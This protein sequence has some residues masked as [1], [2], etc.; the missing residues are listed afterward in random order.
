MERRVLNLTKPGVRSARGML[1]TG[2]QER[3]LVVASF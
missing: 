2:G 1:R 3:V